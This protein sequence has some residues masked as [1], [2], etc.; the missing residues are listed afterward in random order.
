LIRQLST[1]PTPRSSSPAS[2]FATPPPLTDEQY[3]QKALPKEREAYNTL[4]NEGGTPTHPFELGFDIL[5]DPG[6][7]KDILS[8]WDSQINATYFIFTA[9]LRNWRVF[10][11]YQLDIRMHQLKRGTFSNY[12]QKVRDRRQRHGLEGDVELNQDRDQQSKLQNWIE[13]QDYEWQ[14]FEKFQDDFEK[15]QA[16]LESSRKAL[17]EAGI[18]GFEGVNNSFASYYA[19]SVKH[20]KEEGEARRKMKSAEQ[21][22]K[23]VAK[24]LEVARSLGETV[25]RGAWIGCFLKDVESAQLH[26]ERQ[27]R[28]V[29]IAKREL[30][31]LNQWWD[32]KVIEWERKRRNV[33]EEKRMEWR[34]GDTETAEFQHQMDILGE[35]QNKVYE[36]SSQQFRATEEVKFAEEILKAAQSDSFGETIE[37]A[38]LSR[39]IQKEV[40]SARTRLEESKALAEK[41][42]LKGKVVGAL[43]RV[44]STKREFELQKIL[45]EWIEQQRRKLVLDCVSSYQ[46]IGKISS[47]GQA[48]KSQGRTIRNRTTT[49]A[50][51]HKES[52][53][54]KG[55]KREQHAARTLGP[56]DPPRVSKANRMKSTFRRKKSISSDVSPPTNQAS[57]NPPRRSMRISHLKGSMPP[58][59]R[60]IHLSRVSKPGSGSGGARSTKLYANTTS[61]PANRRRSNANRLSISPPPASSCCKKKARLVSTSVPLR[62]SERILKKLQSLSSQNVLL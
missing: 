8:Y 7:Y 51:G 4:I 50:P 33:P 45:V 62:R 42:E 48:K 15:A 35:L 37:R 36:A 44:S 41:V 2:S 18:P 59:L 30:E 23:F 11:K 31:P 12:Q 61:S 13:F 27:Q 25:D 54:A 5:D 29:E 49:K 60:S 22:L 26:L 57:I 38:A 43:G 20:A 9:Q 55:R 32:A 47:H 1:I 6:E 58:P 56:I 34:S 3:K 52:L 19:L 39:I 46:D 24:R 21:K 10:R 17:A 53:K 40:E 14:R 28:L 16:Q